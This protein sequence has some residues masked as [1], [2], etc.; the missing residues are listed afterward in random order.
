MIW[1]GL[2]ILLVDLVL[3]SVFRLKNIGLA[4]RGV[5]LGM[6]QNF[7]GIIFISVI[8]LFLIG[9]YL[10][11]FRLVGRN[12][13]IAIS[14][15]ALGGMGNIICR[16]IWGS[17]WDFVCLPFLPFCFNLSDVLISF[18]VINYILF[19]LVSPARNS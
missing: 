6:A 8:I 10:Y 3:Q 13:K 16:V 4:N 7:E 2:V 5:S 14:L 12:D 17:V 1:G 11:R 15:I 9:I 19:G 18:G